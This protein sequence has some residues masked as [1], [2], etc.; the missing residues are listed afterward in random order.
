MKYDLLLTETGDLAF[1]SSNKRYKNEM[2][3]F[4]FHV[5]SSDSLCFNFYISDTN[6]DISLP[7]NETMLS[8]T[9]IIDSL[10]D[11]ESIKNP[12][13]GMRFYVNENKTYYKVTEVT[14]DEE[15]PLDVYITSYEKINVGFSGHLKYDFYSF[16][17]QFD[18]VS[19]TVRNKE[20]IHQ[21]I[22]LRLNTELGTVLKSESLGTSLHEYMH[23]NLDSSKLLSKVTSQVKKS[24]EDIL[25]N[26]SV[27]AYIIN[28]DYLNYH[29][30]IKIVIINNEE[31]YYYYI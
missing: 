28:S 29:D 6:E 5:S 22:K 2:L 11:V 12:K 27:S 13:V 10:K 16:V 4:N 3:E 8:F 31:I 25:P 1:V 19:R 7:N 24:I 17:P 20:Y 23:S 15:T 9:K 30:S 14:A 18:K 21:A 26:C